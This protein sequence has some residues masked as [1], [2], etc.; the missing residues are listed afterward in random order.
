[1]PVWAL[2]RF[3]LAGAQSTPVRAGHAVN[4]RG[5]GKGRPRAPGA[6]KAQRNRLKVLTLIVSTAAYFIASHY[7]KR[8]LDEMQA[9]PGFTRSL[10]TFC[11]AVLI[12]YGVAFAVDWAEG[13]TEK[14]AAGQ[15]SC[16]VAAAP[17]A[18]TY[19]FTYFCTRQLSVSAT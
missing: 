14:H 12:A 13:L 10:L 7:I 9:P 6:G 11:A 5:R 4:L 19:F 1:M 8:Y 15:R 17:A 18:T 3:S 2:C 16:L